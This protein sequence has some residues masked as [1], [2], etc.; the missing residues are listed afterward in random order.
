VVTPFGT[1]TFRF[2]DIESSPRLWDE[3]PDVMAV[4]LARHDALVR[5]VVEAH[6]G[7]VFS[8]GGDGF[9]VAFGSARSALAAA[10]AAQRALTGEPWP[11][12]VELWVRMG[13]HTGEAEERGGDYFGP[14]VN[15]AARVMAAAHGG[16]GGFA[17]T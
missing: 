10:V 17:A 3:R 8:T 13:L 16:Q 14:P 9:A 1:V 15:R 7:F 4:A 12:P 2:T 11:E 6:D 5:S